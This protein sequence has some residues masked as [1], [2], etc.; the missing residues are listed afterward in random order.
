MMSV[1]LHACRVGVALERFGPVLEAITATP[2]AF[3]Y[4][5]V[6]TMSTERKRK[7]TLDVNESLSFSH[8]LPA[9][10]RGQILPSKKTLVLICR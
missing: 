4:G 5:S 2:L 3:C 7:F 10:E 1:S 6:L 8:C 9:Y